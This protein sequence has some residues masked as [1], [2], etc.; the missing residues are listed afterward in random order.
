MLPFG[1]FGDFWGSIRCHSYSVLF[2]SRLGTGTINTLGW[3]GKPLKEIQR[4]YK[5]VHSVYVDHGF[6][7]GFT[8]SLGILGAGVLGAAAGPV[9]AVL[10]ADAA[11]VITRKALGNIF[12]DSYAKSEDENYKVSPG[13][14]FSNILAT[15]SGAVGA[16][17]GSPRQSLPNLSISSKTN[18]G[19]ED[20]TFFRFWII[21]PGMA[22]I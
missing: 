6:L 3:L 18:T 20:D 13:R 2:W 10:A 16:D 1:F 22:P 15:A 14:D 19:F 21:L 7:P 12:K 9:G 8:A 11:G 4:D 5:F 17:A